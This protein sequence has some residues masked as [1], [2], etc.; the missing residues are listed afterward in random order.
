VKNYSRAHLSDEALLRDLAAAT[1]R[2]R[3][4]TAEVLALIAEVDERKLYLPAGYPSMFAYCVGELHLSEDSSLRRITAARA[5]KR[6]PAICSAVTRGELHLTAVSR[7]AP[8]LTEGNASELI[9]A[10]T[11]RSTREIETLLAERFPQTDLLTWVAA[12]PSAELVSGRVDDPQVVAESALDPTQLVPGRVESCAKVTPLSSQSVALQATLQA[13]TYEKLRYAQELLGH[14]IP[15]GDIDRLL[16]KLLDLALPRIEKQRFGA[17]PR[18]RS[19]RTR[20]SGTRYVPVRVR[21]EVWKRDGGRCTFVSESG[22][23]CEE[24]EDLQFDHVLEVARGGEAT[25]DGIRLLCRAHNQYAAGRTFGADFMRHKRIAAAE[26]RA[27]AK[28]TRAKAA[29]E[30]RAAGH[31]AD[32]ETDVVPYLRA[33]RFSAAEARRAAERC[34]DLPPGTTIEERVRM[35]LKSIRVRGTRFVPA[36]AAAPGMLQPASAG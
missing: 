1:A 29:R 25:V 36:P 10:A 31:P 24:R 21:R 22:H 12:S 28:A 19:G 13:S 4:E 33:L 6:F 14:Q 18:P 17:T 16:D 27:A 5:A 3:G 34:A 7:L 30:L 8:H 32:D 11:H 23:R 9:G 20:S 35:A 26:A 2:E 15:S